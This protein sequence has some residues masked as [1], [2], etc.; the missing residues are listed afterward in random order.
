MKFDVTITLKVEGNITG[1]PHKDL[2]LTGWDEHR[3]IQAIKAVRRIADMGLKQAKECVEK[4]G[5]YGVEPQVLIED[6]TNRV[7][8]EARKVARENDIRLDVKVRE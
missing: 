2:Y 8:M 4:C 7:L 3:K 5:A 6:V 1:D